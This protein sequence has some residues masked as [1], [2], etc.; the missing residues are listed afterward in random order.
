MNTCELEPINDNLKGITNLLYVLAA[1][2]EGSVIESE[3][4]LLLANIANDTANMC[5]SLFRKDENQ[6]KGDKVA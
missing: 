1:H 5:E 2:A 6:K 3:E 4:I